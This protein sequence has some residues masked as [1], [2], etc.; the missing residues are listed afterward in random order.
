[1]QPSTVIGI[2]GFATVAATWFAPQ[3]ARVMIR[4]LFP[5]PIEF[6][7]LL[8]LDGTRTTET[9][10]LRQVL[11][12]Y[13]IHSDFTRAEKLGL[14]IDP[15]DYRDTYQQLR[16]LYETLAKEGREKL[17]KRGAHIQIILQMVSIA[18]SLLS[19]GVIAIAGFFLL[20]RDDTPLWYTVF[21]VMATI[22][23]V[24]LL[25]RVV[26]AMDA[27]DDALPDFISVNDDSTARPGILMAICEW[28]RP[29]LQAMHSEFSKC[30]FRR[31]FPPL[32]SPLTA[33]RIQASLIAV[34]YSALNYA[35]EKFS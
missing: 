20:V 10:T 15:N 13:P 32:R 29:I 7:N 31:L 33:W 34:V 14:E 22:A 17:V 21:F 11:Q 26:A 3:V 8:K 23:T 30:F 28:E 25:M 5:T 12:S 19:L 2:A 9:L 6:D 1:M 35:L 27:H 4:T 16:E 24:V 18:N